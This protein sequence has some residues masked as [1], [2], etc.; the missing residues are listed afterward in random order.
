LPS[1]APAAAPKRQHQLEQGP[2]RKRLHGAHTHDEA[3]QQEQSEGDASQ[4]P[5]TQRWTCATPSTACDERAPSSQQ[6]QSPSRAGGSPTTWHQHKHGGQPRPQHQHQPPQPPGLDD[7]TRHNM[8]LGRRRAA[9]I[10]TDILLAGPSAPVQLSSFLLTITEL[11]ASRDIKA[12]AEAI[13]ASAWLHPTYPSAYP[14]PGMQPPSVAAPPSAA[15]QHPQQSVWPHSLQLGPSQRGAPL[16]LQPRLWHP[17]QTGPHSTRPLLPPQQQRKAKGS[18]PATGR[19]PGSPPSTGSQQLPQCSQGRSGPAEDQPGPGSAAAPAPA[20][21][22]ARASLT[23][24]QRGGAMPDGLVLD[25]RGAV[26]HED[27]QVP[28]AG[29]PRSSSGWRAG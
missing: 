19:S 1:D 26:T 24:C 10:L 21:P 14:P 8:E 16:Q 15:M 11:A 17:L 2:P 5:G 12:R 18:G 28:Q 29:P 22:A 7:F 20:A 27:Q 23:G 3:Q 6:Q 25:L 9:E 4:E 13:T